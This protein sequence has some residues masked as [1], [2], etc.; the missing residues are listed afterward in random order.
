MSR[1]ASLVGGQNYSIVWIKQMAHRSYFLIVN[2]LEFAEVVIYTTDYL[3][4]GNQSLPEL[5]FK[6][7]F[8]H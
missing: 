6:Y 4:V 1:L 3:M 7:L 2:E 8:G 5:S